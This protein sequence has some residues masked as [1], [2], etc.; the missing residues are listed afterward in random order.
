MLDLPVEF[1]QLTHPASF[2]GLGW[3]YDLL[4]ITHGTNATGPEPG[5]TFSEVGLDR[6][7]LSRQPGVLAFEA[8]QVH[9]RA[10]EFLDDGFLPQLL[11]PFRLIGEIRCLVESGLLL[12]DQSRCS[13][14]LP[15]G[16]TCYIQRLRER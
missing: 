13:R 2:H 12:P 11:L 4:D 7:D 15:Q 14:S 5:L 6:L 1:M 16:S 8:L 3:L 10:L 9:A